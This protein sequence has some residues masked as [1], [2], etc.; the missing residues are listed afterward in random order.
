MIGCFFLCVKVLVG[1]RRLA[2]SDKSSRHDHRLIIL[3]AVDTLLARVA[4]LAL[5]PHRDR[6]CRSTDIIM[7]CNRTLTGTCI[8]E[9]PKHRKDLESCQLCT[10]RFTEVDKFE[11][12][13]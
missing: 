7:L 10:S 1:H 6:K 12:T 3:C 8:Q 4:G 11:N 9:E 5:R 13:K 2:G